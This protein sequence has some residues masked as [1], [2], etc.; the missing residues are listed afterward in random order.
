MATAELVSKLKRAHNR[1][2]RH[3]ETIMYGGVMLMGESSVEDNVPT[4]YTDGRNKRYGAEFIEKLAIE[5]VCGLV[6][7]ENL[8]VQLRHIPRHIDLIKEDSKLANAAMDYVVNAIIMGL[9]DKTLCRL[10][11]GGLYD[12]MFID[13]SVREVYNYLKTGRS[14]K[15]NVPQGEPQD[16]VDGGVEIGGKSFKTETLDDHGDGS[17]IGDAEAMEKLSKQVEEATREGV[18]LAGRMGVKVP[19]AIEDALAPDVNWHDETSEFMTDNTRGR[20]EPTWRS[21][22]R[23]HIVNDLLLP[24]VD[25]EK[26]SE[27]VIFIDTSGSIGGEQLSV[28]S[29]GIADICEACNPDKVRV[30]WWDTQVHGEQVFEGNYSNIRNLLK[31]QGGGGTRVSCVSEYLDRTGI[32]ADCAIGFTDGYLEPNIKWDSTL[33]TLW[34]VTENMGIKSKLPGRVVKFN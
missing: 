7:H 12:P 4:A 29:K 3:N 34:V 18:L 17:E 8:H 6:L 19:R 32:K 21:F 33:P 28:F 31:P 20:E 1:L 11:E 26:L 24:S 16:K 2:F 5:E 13:W 30:L 23:K 9:K 22:H 14:G 27:V 10:P 25:S 15:D